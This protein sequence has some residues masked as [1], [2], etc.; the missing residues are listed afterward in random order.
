MK[1]KNYAFYL[2]FLSAF[3]SCQKEAVQSEGVEAKGETLQEVLAVNPN[4]NIITPT[5]TSVR[6]VSGTELLDSEYSGGGRNRDCRCYM[7]VKSV[8]SNVQADQGWFIG[9]VTYGT[10]P[11]TT[12]N[13]YEFEGPTP[14]HWE[15]AMAA[16][17]TLRPLP[18]IFQELSIGIGLY[19]ENSSAGT[20]MFYVGPGIFEVG[21]NETFIVITNYECQTP[22]IDIRGDQT[23]DYWVSSGEIKFDWTAGESIG[24]G[25]PVRRYF[26]DFACIPGLATDGG[27]NTGQ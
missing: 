3:A 21:L 16:S 18:T 17:Y 2:L 27:Y 25:V 1:M 15:D 6:L 11:A 5:H 26:V 10:G 13:L 12:S 23:G 20:H 14:T 4:I 8:I 7:S 24:A 19:A 9:D 22:K